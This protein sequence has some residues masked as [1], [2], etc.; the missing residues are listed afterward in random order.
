MQMQ[1][2]RKCVFGLFV[3]QDRNSSDYYGKMEEDHDLFADEI[4]IFLS[5]LIS[6][7]EK[8]KEERINVNVV[9]IIIVIIIM[10]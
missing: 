9:I 2:Q 10:V 8:L 7:Q 5:L 3:Y 4:R 1:Y 6:Q